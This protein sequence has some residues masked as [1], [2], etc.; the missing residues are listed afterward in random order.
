MIGP[1]TF[2]IGAPKCGTTSLARYLG[3]HPNVFFCTPK[4]PFFWC[5]DFKKSKHEIKIDSLEEYLDLFNDADPSVHAVIAEGSTRYLQSK[6]AV[7]RIL[8][9][10]PAAKFIVMARNP[11]EL[12]SAYHMEQRYSMHED[13]DSFETAWRLQEA[14]AGGAKIPKGCLEPEFLQYSKVASV[15]QQVDRILDEIP[16]GQ[17]L[18]LV[19]DDLKSDPRSVYLEALKFLELPDDGRCDFAVANASHG[20]RF[21]WIAKLVLT[22]PQV[23]EVPMLAIRKHLW[24]KK[25]SL[26]ERFKSFLN[27]KDKREEISEEFREELS[28]H[29]RDDVEILSKA[30]S[31]DLRH[32]LV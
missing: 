30:V 5:S 23:L 21:A 15:G 14:R 19:M 9:Y 22:P 24:R 11:I 25:Y 12:A 8:E 3:E 27:R 26:I 16:S 2:I 18:I 7:K 13:V 1:N 29:F 32:W 17:L 10:N 6:V 31:R 28:N 20:H 4:E